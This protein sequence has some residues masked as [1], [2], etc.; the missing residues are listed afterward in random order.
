MATLLRAAAAAGIV[1]D[2]VR[3]LGRSFGPA[4]GAK[5]TVHPLVEALSERELQVLRLLATELSGPQIARE[6]YVSVNTLRSHTKHIFG[7]LEVNSRTAAVR[8]AESLGLI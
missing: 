4:S 8:R 6:L 3:R 2:Y 7:K 5:A 1:P